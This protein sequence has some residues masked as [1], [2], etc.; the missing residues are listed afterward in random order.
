[1]TGKSGLNFYPYNH[2]AVVAESG[3]EVVIRHSTLGHLCA[4][5]K[6]RS[7]WLPR[8]WRG[9]YNAD[10]LQ[11]L[12]IHGGITYASESD[13]W[14]VFGLDCGHGGDEEH[15]ELRDSQY[16]LGLAKSMRQQISLYR[17]RLG[18]WREGSRKKR[19]ELM[20]EISG[21]VQVK[22]LS[23]SLGAMIGVLCGMPEFGEE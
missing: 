9:N 7:A 5:T 10:G 6:F 1:M 23:P 8:E 11:Y 22:P 4:Y 19:G 12:A 13:G 17:R 16:V 2:G 21:T 18:E 14:C 15:P 3:H 20:D